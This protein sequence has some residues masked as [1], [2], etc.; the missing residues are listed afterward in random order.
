MIGIFGR[1]FARSEP[2]LSEA[3]PRDA[4][5]LSALH[6]VSFRRGWSD[7]EMA[8]LLA[9]ESVL[10]H[11]AM[12]GRALI[13]FIVSRRAAGEA[14][15]LSV[16]VARSSRGDGIGTALLRLHLRRLAGLGVQAVFLEVDED[17]AAAR[18]LYARAGFGEVA[19]REGYYRDQ[20]GRGSTALVLRRD[21]A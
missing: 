11:R 14:E 18:R 12:R 10:A 3:T 7:G 4:A 20:A 21:L 13:G 2:A 19:R 16:A 9:E 17:N 15:I 5:A 8:A 6:A 1:I